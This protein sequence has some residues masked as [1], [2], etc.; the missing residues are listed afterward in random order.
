MFNIVTK[1]QEEG[2]Q[3]PLLDLAIASEITKDYDTLLEMAKS[4]VATSEASKKVSVNPQILS[5]FTMI[6]PPVIEESITVK[7]QYFVESSD[8]DLGGKYNNELYKTVKIIYNL[9][10]IYLRLHIVI[11]SSF[12]VSLYYVTLFTQNVHT[13]LYKINIKI[14]NFVLL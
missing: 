1:A 14:I 7:K 12:F 9:Y 10:S 13:K 6:V 8:N 4:A 11:S 3:D 2:I 5:H